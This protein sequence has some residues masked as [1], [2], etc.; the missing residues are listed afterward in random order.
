MESK[1]Q[2]KSKAK[3]YE[4]NAY[5]PNKSLPKKNKDMSM[6]DIV[7]LA[8][9]AKEILR[10]DFKKTEWG[11]IILP[12]MVLR[13]LGRVL[14]PTKT[15]VISEYEKIKKEKPE[16]VEARLNK[17]TGYE[18]H[19][20]SKFNLDTL[21]VDD[22]NL[23]KNIQAYIRGF[24]DN[25]KD[26]FENFAFETSLNG[27]E[28]QNILYQ[29]VERFA[30]SEMDFDPAKIDNHMMGTIYEEIVRR[31]NEATNEEAG[32]HFTPR[33]VITLMV[34]LLFSHEKDSLT[35][36]GIVRTIYDPA[37]GTGGMLSV[38]SDYIEK[39]NSDAIID[40]YGEEINPETYAVCKS[41]MLIKGLELDRIKLGNSL[42]GG[43]NGDGFADT[44][45]HYMLSN[46]PFG[47]DWGKYEK[48]I[49]AEAEKGFDGKFGV[50]LPRKSDGSFLFLL[51][52]ISK[53]K[54]K[55]EGGSRIAIVLN[56]SPLFT[57]EA[58]SGESNIRKW[59][60]ENDML[61]AIV[62]MPDQLFYNTG[63]FTYIWIVSNNKDKKRQGKIQLINAISEDFYQKMKS[64]LGKKRNEISNEQIK[65][66]TEIYDS[67]KEGKFSK[68]FDNEDF[69]YNRITVNR[70]LKRNFQ[71]SKERLEKLQQEKSFLKLD[72]LKEKPKQPKC[73]DVLKVLSKMPTKTYKDH[74]EFSTDLNSAFTKADF[75]ITATIQKTIE[76]A[77]S[78]KDEEATAQKD[79]KEN[80][81]AD[82]ELRDHENIPLKD[83]IDKYFAKEVLPYVPD[84]WIDDSTRSNIGYEI[85]FTRHFYVYKP[86]RP[87]EEIDKEIRQLQKEISKGL[88]ELMDG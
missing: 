77:L 34:N 55:E 69:G 63:I 1:K 35:K 56:G 61:E 16:Y 87:L 54:P 59:V 30:S 22:R 11:K 53:M 47:V 74:D 51:S 3:K 79:S 50:G 83:D 39:L 31:A 13:R 2:G 19:N 25:V 78:E 75:K 40:V 58:G 64:S 7:G 4:S 71:V 8:W 12:F 33:E 21:K 84:A 46:P 73:K 32:H 70:P 81:I 60:I 23:Q 45:F 10:D 24:S 20:N 66:I 5:E 88:E 41:D 15:K 86:L 49:K 17:I 29:M 6:N 36:K 48:G 65:S 44:K 62:A 68:I 42:I 37:A 85:P 26:I 57:G 38:A 43:K 27:L 72:E 82:S 14:E 76:N 18:F 28:K 52:M 80:L 67:F 9:G